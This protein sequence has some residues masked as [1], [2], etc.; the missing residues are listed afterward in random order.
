MTV[1]IPEV[2]EGDELH[3]IPATL[4]LPVVLLV[5]L[6]HFGDLGQEVLIDLI[7]KTHKEDR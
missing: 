2:P 7:A 5:L 4:L 3:N 6:V 1:V